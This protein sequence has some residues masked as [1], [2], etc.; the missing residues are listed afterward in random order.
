MANFVAATIS[1]GGGVS[2]THMGAGQRARKCG[3]ACAADCR[4]VVLH[5]QNDMNVTSQAE[6]LFPPG[7]LWIYLL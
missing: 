6:G 4:A 5:K 1:S 3:N 7:T 2:D